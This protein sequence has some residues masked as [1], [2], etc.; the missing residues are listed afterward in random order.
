MAATSWSKNDFDTELEKG[1]F[2]L[3]IISP[4]YSLNGTSSRIL[5]L[6]AERK[7]SKLSVQSA[8]W[9]SSK[10]SSAMVDSGNEQVPR[11]LPSLS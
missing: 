1:P 6:M 4:L 11:S 5:T 2:P 7:E 3:N 10:N 8:S 9:K